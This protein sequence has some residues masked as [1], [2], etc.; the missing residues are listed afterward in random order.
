MMAKAAQLGAAP[1]ATE[2]RELPSVSGDAGD[3]QFPGRPIPP[4]PAYET[5]QRSSGAYGYRSL[6]D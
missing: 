2:S 4:P 1:A 6:L 3:G 5:V